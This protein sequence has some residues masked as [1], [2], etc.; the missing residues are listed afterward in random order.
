M[1][2][3]CGT[4]CTSQVTSLPQTFGPGQDY[5]P[6]A[7]H[8]SATPPVFTTMAAKENLLST[9]F[10]SIRPCALLILAY[11]GPKDLARLSRSQQA[12]RVVSNEHVGQRTGR[13]PHRKVADISIEVAAFFGTRHD[14]Q[15][16]Y[17]LEKPARLGVASRERWRRRVRQADARHEDTQWRALRQHRLSQAI[18][19]RDLRALVKLFVKGIDLNARLHD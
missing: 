16:L 7:N 13:Q 12:V 11:L 15:V 6:A 4:E 17:F 14:A 8:S 1:T 10:E 3:L 5:K 9:L 2:G 18:I 19:R